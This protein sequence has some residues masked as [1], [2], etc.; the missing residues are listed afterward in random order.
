[1]SPILDTSFSTGT[2]LLIAAFL[3]KVDNLHEEYQRKLAR[4]L[5]H[6]FYTDLYR[7]FDM[8]STLNK[9]L[10]EMCIDKGILSEN[11][12]RSVLSTMAIFGEDIERIY[13]TP[14]SFE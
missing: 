10:I 11:E 5:T 8:T 12:R 2:E 4:N 1:M 14:A 6:E 13:S 3:S 9:Q 7:D